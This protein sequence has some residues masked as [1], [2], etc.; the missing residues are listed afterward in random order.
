MI[1][2]KLLEE[3]EDYNG[4]LRPSTFE[5]YIGQIELIDRLKI[6]IQASNERND[7]LGHILLTGPPRSWKNINSKCYS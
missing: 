5:D 3:R 2:V 1:D 6:A 7:A 4:A